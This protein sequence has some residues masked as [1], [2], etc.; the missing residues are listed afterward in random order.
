MNDD[1]NRPEPEALLAEAKKEGRGRFK[2]FLGAAPGVGKTYAM[3]EAALRRKKEEQDVVIGIVETHGRKE[4]EALLQDLEIV[5]RKILEYRGK[6]FQEMDIDLIL[7][8]KP[9]LVLVDE[10]A[11]TNIE[12]SRHT[13]RWQDV[14]EI[15]SA[16]INVYST[17]NIQH[18]ESLNDIVQRITR[19]RIKETLP[20]FVLNMADEITLVDLTPEELIQRL[21][22]G[23]VYVPEQAAMAVRHYFARSNLTALR[24]LAMRTAAEHVDSDLIDYM[25]VHGVS[26]TLPARERLIVCIDESQ[27]AP[28]LVRMASR[29][30]AKD[31]IAWIALYVERGADGLLTEK[32]KD[33]ISE[34]LRLAEQLGGESMT[35]RGGANVADDIIAFART[36]NATRLLI[37]RSGRSSLTDFLVPSIARQVVLKAEDFDITLLHATRQDKSKGSFFR[38]VNNFSGKASVQ[39]FIKSTLSILPAIA[40]AIVF[41]TILL[42]PNL[43]LIFLMPVLFTGVHYGLWPSMY[44]AFLSLA[45]YNFFFTEPFYTFDV[46]QTADISTLLFFLLVA[47]VTGNMAVRLKHQIEALRTT[48]RRNAQMHDFSRKLAAALTLEDIMQEMVVSISV[49]LKIRAAVV[50]PEPKNKDKL[51]LASHHPHSGCTFNKTDW[52]AAEWSWRNGKPAGIG[53]DTLPAASWYFIPLRGP[54]GTVALLATAPMEKGEDTEFFL[55]PPYRRMLYSFCDQAALAIERAQLSEDIEETRILAETEKL[56]SALLSSISHDLRTPLVSIIGSATSLRDLDKNL[57]PQGKEELLQNILNEAER[58]N[59]FIQN[60]LDMTKLGHGK[61]KP[62]REWVEFRDVLGRALKR[63][64]KELSGYTI[65][66]ENSDDFTTLNVDAVLMEQAFVNILDNAAKYAPR[67]SV[68]R[69]SFSKESGRA[70]IRFSDEGPGIPEHE[71]ELVFDMFYRVKSTD[72][73]IAGTGLGLSICR[74]LIEAHGGKIRAENGPNGKGTTII[75]TFPESLAGNSLKLGRIIG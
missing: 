1:I 7:S 41:H 4:T 3:L 44:T 59:R 29:K 66:I 15:L 11:H 17:L 6:I 49:D 56:R 74:G 2:I 16:G 31:N 9:Y 25:K 23:K 28:D 13:K 5:P 63:L 72:A 58:L 36:R 69:I 50:L 45:V 32:E 68:I 64:E 43:S 20:D 33:N 42:L 73:K 60:L 14:E 47:F 62:K 38:H 75:L 57:S 19:V 34:T 24:E 55:S 46:H 53:S 65:E 10:L 22:E 54:K 51:Y 8:R 39:D 70:V 71:C 21:R 61:L 48:A 67:G 52:G 30:A 37:G 27:S 40:L 18:L 35:I 12:G 26:R